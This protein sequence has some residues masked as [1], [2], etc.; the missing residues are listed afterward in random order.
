MASVN[1]ITNTQSTLQRGF[2][3]NEREKG[4]ALAAG[5]NLVPTIVTG[6]GSSK[7]SLYG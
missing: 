6:F 4:Q 7:L 5:D 2:S 1:K 3:S